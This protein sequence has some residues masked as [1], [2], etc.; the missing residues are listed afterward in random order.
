MKKNKKLFLFLICLLIFMLMATSAFAKTVTVTKDGS[1][2]SVDVD[3][4]VLASDVS[5]MVE[6]GTTLV[7]MRVIF[8]ALNAS[9]DYNSNEKSITAKRDTITVLLVLGDTKAYVNG[10]EKT[11]AV[12]AKAVN[13]RTMVPLRFVSEALGEKV[14]YVVKAASDPGNTTASSYK[15]T[16]YD[17]AKNMADAMSFDN[18]AVTCLRTAYTYAEYYKNYGDTEFLNGAKSQYASVPAYLKYSVENTSK[19]IGNCGGFSEYAQLKAALKAINAKYAAIS[20]L[21]SSYTADN[22]N[23]VIDY[24]LEI[25]ELWNQATG[26]WTAQKPE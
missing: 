5:P 4:V 18:S 15:E 3:G 7:P 25:S 21:L 26:Y 2:F 14:D 20:S 17:I 24:Y 9:V 10:V 6:N 12:P 11:L 19:A 23:L 8:E 22:L 13:N 16:Y 1:Q